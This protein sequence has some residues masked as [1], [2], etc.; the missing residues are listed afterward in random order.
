MAGQSIDK[1]DIAIVGG[2]LAGGLAAL[3]LAAKRPDLDV[4]LVEERVWE[5]R[6]A[7][8][9]LNPA[10][11]TPVLF[12]EGMP[13]VPGAGII[14]W[15][16]LDSQRNLVI[17]DIE[18]AA[19]DDVFTRVVAHAQWFAANS[20]I[21]RR[22]YQVWNVSWDAPIRAL[23]VFRSEHRAELDEA[24]QRL[25]LGGKL[26]LV[27][28]LIAARGAHADDRDHLVRARQATLDQRGRRARLRLRRCRKRQCGKTSQHRPAVDH[29]SASLSVPAEERAAGP[30]R[31]Q[32]P[33]PA[34]QRGIAEL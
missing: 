7:F 6:E 20:A 19:P 34:D 15:I 4:R 33:G 17:A 8:L 30:R 9:A 27:Q 10:A 1:C 11:A 32:S 12:A 26:G 18:G 13:A 31:G 29:R 21:V 3:A 5:R 2:G 24:L 22:M 23:C 28:P 14:D 25:A 16:A